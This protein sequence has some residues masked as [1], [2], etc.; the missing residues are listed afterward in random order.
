LTEHESRQKR[1]DFRSDSNY[2]LWYRKIRRVQAAKSD[3]WQRSV[4]LNLS[5]GGAAIS[6]GHGK[7]YEKLTPG[8]LLEFELVMPGGPVFGIARVVRIL[9]YRGSS[10]VAGISF[11]SVAPQDRDKIAKTVL[12]DGLENRHGKDK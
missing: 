3:E 4:T 8:D 12:N 11:V 7:G 2:A 9:D 1:Y 10:N 5:A 6:V